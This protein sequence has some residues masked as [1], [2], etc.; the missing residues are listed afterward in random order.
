MEVWGH[1]PLYSQYVKGNHQVVNAG[2]EGPER[3]HR[4]VRPD[5]T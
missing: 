4:L 2:L 3:Q 1:S 5:A